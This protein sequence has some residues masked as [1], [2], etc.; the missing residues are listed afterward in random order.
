MIT[1][2]PRDRVHFGCSKAK[3]SEAKG[4]VMKI[5]GC[6]YH[7]SFQQI[8][9][10]DTET[11]EVIE[12]RLYHADGEAQRF[13]ESLRGPVRV[14]VETSGNMLWFER[15]LAR[16]KHELWIGDAGRIHWLCPRKQQLTDKRDARHI[17]D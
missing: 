12:R 4:A 3:S 7:P 11:G 13:Y 6:D 5:I 8:A 15:L 17:L 1:T 14:G 9:M 10:L 16:L 2:A